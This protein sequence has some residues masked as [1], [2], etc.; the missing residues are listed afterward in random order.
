MTRVLHLRVYDAPDGLKAEIVASPSL[1]RELNG[2]GGATCWH[3]DGGLALAVELE[4]RRK[5]RLLRYQLTELRVQRGA[6][7]HDTSREPDPYDVTLGD[8]LT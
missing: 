5:G 8:F 4:D 2:H 6:E 3:C 7:E 1:W